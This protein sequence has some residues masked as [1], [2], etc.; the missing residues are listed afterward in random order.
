MFFWNERHGVFGLEVEYERIPLHTSYRT[1]Q[2]L[3]SH[4]SRVNARIREVWDLRDK[5]FGLQICGTEYGTNGTSRMGH[6]ASRLGLSLACSPCSP[7]GAE[8]PEGLPAS[9]GNPETFCQN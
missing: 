5:L 3:T 2:N 7:L 4:M 1:G 8:T 6:P 9:R